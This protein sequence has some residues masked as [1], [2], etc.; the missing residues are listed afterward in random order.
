MDKI[1]IKNLIIGFGKAG[2]TLAADLAKH[3]EEVILVE[4][5]SSMYG[6]TCINIGC[7]PSK[8]LLVEAERKPLYVNQSVYFEQAMERKNALI[9]ALRAANYKKLDDLEGVRII[10]ATASFIDKNTVLLKGEGDEIEITAQRIFINTGTTSIS[11]NIKG[12]DGNHVYNSTQLLSLNTFPK[13]LVIIGGGYISLEFAC[14]FQ[15]FG[16]KVTI[17]EA[18]D[19]FLAREDRDVADE[20]LRILNTRGIE[21]MLNSKTSELQEN[22]DYT[23]VITSQGNFDAE[24]VLV[25]IGRKPA[26]D[27]LELHNA[28]I[29]TDERGYIITNDYLQVN[30]HIWAMGDVAKTP[31][32]TYMSLDDYRIVRDQ[33][34]GDSKRS[35]LD[36]K[37]IATSVFTYPTL[38]QVGLTEQQAKSAGL[39]FEVKKIAANAIPKAKVLGQTDGLLKAI[40]EKQSNRILGVTL[41]CAEAHELI[42]I[43]KLAID[44]NITAETLKNQIFT[45]PTMA[46]AL[47]DLFA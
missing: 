43:C 40:V 35:R 12:G 24:A 26:T 6:G 2:K 33:L 34:F 20:M 32:F 29:K 3:G 21:V 5:S 22:D 23:T 7:I 47:N 28:D 45:H 11:L 10:N 13:R 41:F 30:E 44:N 31:Q 18:S 27:E 25:A 46:E 36:R 9:S 15:A 37:N 39:Q 19:T 16:S 14:M 17:L 38:A 42:N 4:K 1:N 8:K